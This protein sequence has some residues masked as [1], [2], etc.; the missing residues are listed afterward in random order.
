MKPRR[1]GV[2]FSLDFSVAVILGVFF[3][4]LGPPPHA[5]EH[6]LFNFLDFL[7]GES[8]GIPNG[9]RGLKVIG[10]LVVP[11]G[12]PV[13]VSPNAVVL[14][15]EP[16]SHLDFNVVVARFKEDFQGEGPVD[17]CGGL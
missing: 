5:C 1:S 15:F 2:F 6:F 7:R 17:A 11:F 3:C 9:L 14:P 4:F 8:C 12:A 16:D 10:P 13:L